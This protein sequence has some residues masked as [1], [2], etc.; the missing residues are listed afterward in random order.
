MLLPKVI[1]ISFLLPSILAFSIPAAKRT[2]ASNASSNN[3]S[4]S[5]CV[6]SASSRNCWDEK[7][8]ID[9]DSE[10]KWPNTGVIV[11]VRFMLSVSS[12]Q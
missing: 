10:I 7:Y 2:T 6:N 5:G 9:T 1:L 11:P 4:T 8:S 12:P 3:N